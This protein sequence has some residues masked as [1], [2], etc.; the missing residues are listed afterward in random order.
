M[1]ENFK[2]K[3]RVD[4]LSDNA[5]MIY[6]APLCAGDNGAHTWR[7]TVLRGGQAA[8]LSGMTAGCYA[9]RMTG[10]M[11]PVYFDAGIEGSVV[12]AQLPQA[13]YDLG[14]DVLVIMRVSDP[15]GRIMALAALQ[16][17]SRDMIGGEAV[18]PGGVVIDMT[19]L[20]ARVKALE[21]AA[22]GV[23]S[24]E[25]IAAAVNAYL[26]EHP[27]TGGA[28]EAEAAQI[29]ANKAA[30]EG[31]RTA[32]DAL[33][34]GGG[35]TGGEAGS[36]AW[37]NVTGKPNALPNPYALTINGQTYDGSAPVTVTIGGADGEDGGY[38]TPSVDSAGSLTWTAS[39][40]GMPDAP[41]ANIMGP[42]GPQGPAGYTPEKG[43]D[44]WTAEDK[45][46]MVAD[47]LAALPD[48]DEVSY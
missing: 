41:G 23:I 7:V 3:Q 29:A 2:I 4:L 9:R 1:S 6:G 24:D 25:Q 35:S 36:V 8:D 13:V 48:G 10:D 45:A 33:K 43:T 17:T 21:D 22:G 42:E 46:E 44:Y 40:A 16:V 47:V 30:I 12:S 19:G 20:T 18:Q 27:V 32:V 38:Y 39:K 5:Q 15:E 28:T 37:E 31:L 26:T 34:A 14:G 11:T